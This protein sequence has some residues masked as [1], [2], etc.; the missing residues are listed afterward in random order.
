MNK[1]IAMMVTLAIGVTLMIYSASR[2]LALLQLTL[3]VGQRDMAFLALAAFDGGLVG[4]TL[5]FM[6]GSEG[7]WQRAISAMMIVICLAGVIVG[8]G[9]DS[10]LGALHGGIVSAGALDGSFGLTVVLA[11]VAIIAANIAATV[12]FHV[13]SPSNRRHMQEESFSDHI[14]AAAFQKSNEAIPQ[15]AAQLAAE[16][17]ASR[18]ARLNAKYQTL[19]AAEQRALPAPRATHPAAGLASRPVRRVSPAAAPDWI[20]SRLSAAGAPDAGRVATFASE[21]SVEVADAVAAH[22]KVKRGK[23]A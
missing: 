6:F 8:F 18:M 10:L 14:E 4:W 12:A 13:L 23:P 19:I 15:L 17:T 9:A 1:A 11:T 22:P 16:L 2:T 5:T 20:T 7:A 21:P 3:P